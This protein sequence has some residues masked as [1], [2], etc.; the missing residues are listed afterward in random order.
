MH[1]ARSALLALA[2]SAP[3]FGLSG[4][5]GKPDSTYLPELLTAAK[6]RSLA[7]DRAWLREQFNRLS[8]YRSGSLIEDA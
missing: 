5:G 8:S 6:S 3:A 4:E 2:I 1:P 7:E